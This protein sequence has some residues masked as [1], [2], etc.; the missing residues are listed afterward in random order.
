MVTS[1]PD[2]IALEEFKETGPSV[3]SAD[4]IAKF[5]HHSPAVHLELR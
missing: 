4:G 5:D 1:S 3:K 2:S